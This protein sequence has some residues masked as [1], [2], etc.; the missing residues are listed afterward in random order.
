[1]EVSLNQALLQINF[2]TLKEFLGS[3]R[4]SHLVCEMIVKIET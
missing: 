1:M 4:F 3:L 2:V